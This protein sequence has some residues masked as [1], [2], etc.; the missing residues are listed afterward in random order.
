M[1]LIEIDGGE[2]HYEEF[3]A[4]FPVLCFAPGSLNSRIDFWRH[5]PRDPGKPS[6]LF[7]P[8]AELAAHFRVIVMD[9][10]NAGR[11]RARIGP[12]DDWHSYAKDHIA[13]LDHLKVERCH[14]LGACIGA[15]FCLK[16]CELIPQRIVTAVLMQPIGRVPENIDYTRRELEST[17]GPGMRKANPA[18]DPK[19]LRDLG[20]RLFAPEFVHSVTREFV[21]GCA[22]PML[23]MPGNDVAHPA[24]ISDELVRL[25][26][27]AEVL[28]YWKGEGRSSY[29]AACARD[30]LLRNTPR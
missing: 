13:L 22:I 27:L 25:A 8:T 12:A 6:P 9:Q 28:K 21:A 5:S 11:S 7:D 16:L 10:R 24:A 20:E 3:G 14:T 15:S 1:P 29:A 18:L 4:G 2:L 17:W 26:P 30:F 19:E 23:V